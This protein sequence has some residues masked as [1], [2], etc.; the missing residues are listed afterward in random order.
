M[1]ISA[2]ISTLAAAREPSRAPTKET[3]GFAARL[4]ASSEPDKAGGASGISARDFHNISPDDLLKTINGLIRSGEV[5]LD[6][7]SSLVGIMGGMLV[8]AGEASP[9]AGAR[10]PIDA[11][12]KLIA[13]REFARSRDDIAG[14]EFFDKGLAVLDRFQGTISS[15]DGTV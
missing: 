6:D 10:T 14:V 4:N 7:T 3:T 12:A 1:K 5:S 8:H 2:S 13:G 11:F 9:G 15:E